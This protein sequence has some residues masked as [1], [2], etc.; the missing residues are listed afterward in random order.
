MQPITQVL[1]T[2]DKPL[3]DELVTDSGLKLYI[4]P[5]YKKE[6]QATVM[7]TISHLPVKVL[8]KYKYIFDQLKVGDEV[9]ISYRVVADFCFQSDG[10]RFMP[11]TDENPHFREY[12]NAKGEWVKVYALPGIISTK[13]VGI[14]QNKYREVISGVEGDE[15]DMERWLAQFPLGKTDIYSFNNLFEFD[16]EDYWKCDLD[17]IF[18]KKVKGHWVAVGNRTVCK[19]VEAEVPDESLIDIH[20]GHK[21]KIRYQDRGRV[22]TGGKDKGIKKGEVIGFSPQFLEKYRFDNLEYYLI[23][24][25]YIQGKWN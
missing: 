19:P 7:A 6:W 23:N 14:Y 13:W 4:S 2:V 17:E 15:S 24:T 20:K 18:A 5:D 1:L 11:T 3:Q 12:V 22:I 10:D 21:V 25:D 9:A 8:P 16:G